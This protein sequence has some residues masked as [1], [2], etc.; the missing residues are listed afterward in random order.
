MIEHTPI[1]KIGEFGLIE[2]IKSI[3]EPENFRIDENLIKGISDDTAVFKTSPGKLQ[4]LTTDAMVEGIHFDLTFTSL[5]HLGWKAIVTNISDIAAM[6]GTPRYALV[7]VAI[8]QKFSVEMIEDFYKGAVR[9]CKKYDCLI[10]GGDTTASSGNLVVSVTLFGEADPARVVYRYGAKAGDL[11]CVSGHLGGAHAGLKILLREKEN[12]INNSEQFSPNLDPYK[13]ALEKYLMPKARMDLVKY[14]SDS[15]KINSMIDISDGLAS[16]VHHICKNSGVGAEIWEHNIPVHAITQKI[17]E[18]FSDNV[19]DYALLGGEEYE[20][21][22]TLS[23]I[24]FEKLEKLTPDVT[25]LGRITDAEKGLNLIREGGEVEPLPFGGW[26]HFRNK[27]E[28]K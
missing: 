26:E 17:A 6:C 25:I 10:V 13:I 11:I 14:F 28:K 7:T 19:V 23:D 15:I 24:E 22:F 20:L 5:Q 2:K 27:V 1:N 16:E 12:F 3:V 8:P 4:L 9:A 21:L 18:E